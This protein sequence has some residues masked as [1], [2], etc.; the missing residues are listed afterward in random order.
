MTLR[1]TFNNESV[2]LPHG[3][4]GILDRGREQGHAVLQPVDLQLVLRGLH[5]DRHGRGQLGGLARERGRGAD[6]E[7]LVD[8]AELDD[9]RGAVGGGEDPDLDPGEEG[10][11]R[12]DRGARVEARVLL[13][14]VF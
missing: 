8:G 2:V 9:G 11:A 12:R 10:A 14:H 13:R 1:P 3:D 4:P 6:L 5:V 7:G